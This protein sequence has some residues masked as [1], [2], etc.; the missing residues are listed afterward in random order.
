MMQ[1]PH[2]IALRHPSELSRTAP[3]YSASWALMPKPEVLFTDEPFSALDPFIRRD[4]QRDVLFAIIR[5]LGVTTVLVT[6]DV[7]GRPCLL[8]PKAIL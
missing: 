8:L 2:D 7:R 6:H 5:S 3:A 4:L 1:L